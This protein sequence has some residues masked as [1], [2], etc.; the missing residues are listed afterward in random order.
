MDGL[1]FHYCVAVLLGW[2]ASLAVRG[3]RRHA[4]VM[5]STAH[6]S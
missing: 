5:T 1:K 6:L 4:A 2:S 3:R